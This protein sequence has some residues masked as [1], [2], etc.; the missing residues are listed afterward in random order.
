[1]ATDSAT[2]YR[3]ILSKVRSTALAATAAL[4]NSRVVLTPIFAPDGMTSP[5]I[6]IMVPGQADIP[7]KNSGVG[8]VYEEFEVAMIQQIKRDRGGTYTDAIGHAT[9][10]LTTLVTAIRGD[11]LASNASGLHNHVTTNSEGPV[12]LAGWGAI[13]QMDED[14]DFL[15]HI[16]RYQVKY[17]LDS[18]A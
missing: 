11:G 1:M 4:A 3:E 17:E 12:L 18:Y 15:A 13:R 16:D 5:F 6:Q 2:I 14:P 8:L 10:S 7:H 9:T